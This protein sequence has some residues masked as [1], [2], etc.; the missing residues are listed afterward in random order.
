MIGDSQILDP[1]YLKTADAI[2]QHLLIT[3]TQCIGIGGESGSGK[4]VT[5]LALQHQLNAKGIETA[6]LHQDDYF[7]LPPKSNHLKRQENLEWVGLKEVNLSLLNEHCQAFKNAAK[8]I[9][10][11]L[12][13]YPENSIS[14]E[15]LS[16][17][18]TQILLVEGTYCLNLNCLDVRI[19][20][21]RNYH[22]TLE[23]R[24]AR[25]RDLIDDFT[26]QVLEIEHQLIAPLAQNADLLVDTNYQVQPCKKS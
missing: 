21:S 1:K 18:N 19:F 9:Q 20:M 8:S 13:N 4:S 25:A 7:F 22:Q 15:V 10:K 3:K 2:L 23:N 17:E 26:N 16:L 11:P 24:R 6:L 5:A 12:V 14:T